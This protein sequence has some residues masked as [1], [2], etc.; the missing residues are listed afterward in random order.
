MGTDNLDGF[1]NAATEDDEA[2]EVVAEIVEPV[3]AKGETGETP[4]VPPT[5]E[6]TETA[7]VPRAALT[8]ERRKRQ[9]LEARI[10]DMERQQRPVEAPQAKPD[11]FEDPDGYTAWVEER[12]TAAALAKM[13][14]NTAVQRIEFS[15]M[16]AQ[17]K[18]PDY[19]ETIGVFQEL[20][21]A[22]PALNAEL[23]RNANPAEYA[24]RY[25][26]NHQETQRLGSLD[27]DDI[28]AKLRA[29][30]LA[31]QATQAP[32]PPVIKPSLADAQSSRTTSG[33]P[34][35]PPSLDEILGRK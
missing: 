6:I 16:I 20:L 26:K 29:E 19:A 11:M 34:S 21:S 14:A 7:T 27:L 9:E 15:A 24:Y 4:S 10:A 25:A 30:I 17:G 28:R 35:G 33:T 1:L 13:G 22:N 31:E 32:P 2:P 18:Y 23:E 5:P 8:D 3:E 12:A